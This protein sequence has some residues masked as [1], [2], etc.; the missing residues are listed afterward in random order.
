MNRDSQIET[1][2][3]QVEISDP[4]DIQTVQLFTQ[5]GED[6]NPPDGSTVMV[7][8]VGEAWKTGV[9]VNDGIAPTVEPGE[10]KLYSS[11]DGEIKAYILFVKDGVLELNGN[12]DFAVR[13]NALEQAFNE[14]R[15]DFNGHTHGGVDTGG[16]NTQVPNNP[17]NAD[18]SPAKVDSIKVP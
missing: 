2:Q 11:A 1:L 13:F 5:A 17:S 4:E 18:I 3:L 14:F 12:D 10:K 8:E 16:G 6:T 7:E 9:A 15:S